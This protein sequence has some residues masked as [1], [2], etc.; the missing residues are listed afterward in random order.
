MIMAVA[1]A[2]AETA[3]SRAAASTGHIRSVLVLGASSAW[4][5]AVSSGL[6]AESFIAI[7][8]ASRRPPG[9]AMPPLARASLKPRETA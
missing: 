6:S 4:I 2:S 9:R 8:E 1:K 3:A 5:R 7:C